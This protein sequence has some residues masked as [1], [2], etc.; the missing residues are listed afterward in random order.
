MKKEGLIYSI[1]IASLIFLGLF[2]VYIGYIK[3]EREYIKLKAEYCA[4]EAFSGLNDLLANQYNSSNYKTKKGVENMIT[5]RNNKLIECYDY[6]NSILFSNSEEN[7]HILNINKLFD[8]Q[9]KEIE[10]YLIRIERIEKENQININRENNCQKMQQE[11]DR[12]INCI[13]KINSLSWENNNKD[14]C[15]KEYNYKRFGV[16]EYD[17]IF[18]LN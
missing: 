4:Q 9:E 10:K 18:F 15:L 1:I 14:E 17:C 11:Y 13:S 3:P 5:E 2:I 7:I 16:D 6:Y 12:Y 8:E